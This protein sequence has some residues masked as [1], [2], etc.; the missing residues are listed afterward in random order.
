[1]TPLVKTKPLESHL[2]EMLTLSSRNLPRVRLSISDHLL[3]VAV[4]SILR[5]ENV[6]MVDDDQLALVLTD[7]LRREGKRIVLLTDESPAEAYASVTAFVTGKVCAVASIRKP[8]AIPMVIQAAC[9]QMAVLPQSLLAAA[10]KAPPLHDR[11]V[12]ILALMIEGLTNANI[13]IRLDLSEA[14]VKR[15]VSALL[16]SFECATRAELVHRASNVGFSSTR[17]L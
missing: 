8:E 16:R 1:M 7:D 5:L 3:R 11:Q 9:E 10:F 14:T 12:R 6:S 17:L 4:E 2:A 15:N 13:G